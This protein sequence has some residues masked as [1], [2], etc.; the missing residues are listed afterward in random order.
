MTST[1]DP[2]AAGLVGGTSDCVFSSNVHLPDGALHGT[3]ARPIGIAF[4]PIGA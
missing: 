4:P 1:T 2:I 3:R